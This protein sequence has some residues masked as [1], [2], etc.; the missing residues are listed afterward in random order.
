MHGNEL[1]DGIVA[2]SETL[3]S[4]FDNIIQLPVWHTFMMNDSR[5]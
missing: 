5:V 3:L 4:D 1:N 2:V